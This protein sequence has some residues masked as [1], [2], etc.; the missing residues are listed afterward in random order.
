MEAENQSGT[1]CSMLSEARLR[2][3][4]KLPGWRLREAAALLLDLDPDDP[5]LKEQ[6]NFRD[7][8]RV[9]LRARSMKVIYSPIRPRRLLGGFE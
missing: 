7:L 5:N 9:L 8:Q 4:A 3:W 2:Y 1:S 6:S